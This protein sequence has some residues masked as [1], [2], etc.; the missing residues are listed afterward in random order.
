MNEQDALLYVAGQLA[1]T[2]IPRPP[3]AT[4]LRLTAYWE[5]RD[6]VMRAIQPYKGEER[7]SPEQPVSTQAGD[8]LIE[9]D[10]FQERVT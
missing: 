9:I 8:V 3:W 6:A 10:E 7:P 5:D 4:H 1:A 2:L